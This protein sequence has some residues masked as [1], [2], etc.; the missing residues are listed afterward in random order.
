[1][2]SAIGACY[3][4]RS[5]I[6]TGPLRLCTVFT[7]FLALRAILVSSSRA[8]LSAAA[9]ADRTPPASQDPPTLAAFYYERG[10]AA[11]RIGRSGQE[12]EGGLSPELV[13]AE[14]VCRVN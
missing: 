4:R 8:Y 6:A 5:S 12:L 2:H 1:M 13:S 7:V 11:A 9:T 3:V 14:P 10:L